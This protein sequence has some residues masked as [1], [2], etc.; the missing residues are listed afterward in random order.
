MT[1]YN[2]V[3]F[4][5]ILAVLGLAIAVAFHWTMHN[6]AISA[7]E[8]EETLR[9]IRATARLPLLLLLSLVTVLVS[10][11]YMASRIHAF[12]RGWISASFLSILLIAVVSIS[13]ALATRA[14]Q[15]Y[16]QE[17]KIDEIRR[18]LVRPL[19]VIPVRLQFALLL[20]IIFLMVARTNLSMSLEI[21]GVGTVIGL[22]W[23]AFAWRTHRY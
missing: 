17:E 22:L 3:L 7:R 15:R 14:L 8:S 5:H 20:T 13:G 12:G 1:I 9:W 19:L 23:S 21:V 10:G 6:K 11:I 18:N 2:F 16:A 4:I